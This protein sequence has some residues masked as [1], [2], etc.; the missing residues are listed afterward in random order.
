[1]TEELGKPS[2]SQKVPLK[3]FILA[4]GYGSRLKPLTDKIPKPLATV[5]GVSLLEAAL[6]KV[7]QA[8]AVSFAVN[9][10]HLHDQ[11]A[12][13]LRDIGRHLSLPDVYVSREM[14][15]I[16]GTG[17]ALVA[18]KAWWKHSPLLVYNGD[19]LSDMVLRQLVE[20]HNQVRPIVTMAVRPQPPTDG[21]RSVWVDRHGYVWAICRR[22]DLTQA[23]K[24]LKNLSP[25]R[26]SEL[27]ECGFACSYM[28]EPNLLN[29]LPER[30]QL[31]DVIS[32][33][34][35]ALENGR[36]I[37]SL[38][39]DGFWADV[40][41]PISLWKTNLEVARMTLQQQDMI[42]GP[43]FTPSV[44]RFGPGNVVSPDAHVDSKAQLKNSVVLAGATVSAAE[45]LTDHIRG[46]GLDLSF[47]AT[48]S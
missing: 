22:Q 28:A 1:M 14:N 34:Q 6:H 37:F 43:S 17:G 13:N 29:Y 44:L 11:I 18:L 39:F 15:Q 30:A 27:T 33:F 36:K 35:S 21:G 48:K 3:A 8:G 16:L 38:S 45:S 41:Q 42:L 24:S 9:T 5:C 47:A 32:G 2:D 26:E 23:L 19:I 10:H 12:M 31:F 40:G 20:C 4:A 25:V 7:K 46:Y